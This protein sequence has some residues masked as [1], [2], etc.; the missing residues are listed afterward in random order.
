MTKAERLKLIRQR[1]RLITKQRKLRYQPSDDNDDSKFEV[2][3]EH[4]R[5]EN[6]EEINF[7]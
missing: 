5:Y 4:V 6:D 2:E 1:H 7:D 3:A